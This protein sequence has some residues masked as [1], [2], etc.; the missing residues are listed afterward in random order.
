MAMDWLR[1]RALRGL[2][3]PPELFAQLAGD[4]K[5]HM[6]EFIE[7]GTLVRFHESCRRRGRVVFMVFWFWFCFGP[8]GLA[9]YAKSSARDS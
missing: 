6:K 9:R 3:C 2:A 1:A 5:Q 7:G 8:L 4:G